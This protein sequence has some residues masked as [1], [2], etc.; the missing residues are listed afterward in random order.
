MQGLRKRVHAVLD[1]TSAHDRVGVLTHR[2]II[3]LILLNIAAVVLESVPALA[4]RWGVLFQ[5]VEIVTVAAF[6]VEYAARIWAA[7]EHPPLEDH[8]PWAARLR[9]ALYPS[10]IIDLVAILPLVLALF[11]DIDLRAAV[12]FRLLRYFKLARYSP[13][14][15]SLTEAVMAERRAL[16]ACLV[17]LFGAVLLCASAMHMVE[18][19][20]QPDKFGTIPDAMYWAVITLTTVGYGDVFPVTPAGKMITAFTA[21]AGLAMLALPVAIVSS[22][23]AREIHRR[24]FVVTWSMVAKVPLF[25]GLDAAAVAEIM[26][27]LQ[28]Q[29][30]DAGELIV[31]R[32][33]PAHSMYFIASGAVEIELPARRLVLQEGRFFG[34][35][36]LLRQSQRSGMVRA[37][38]RTRLLV[39]ESHDLHLVMAAYPEIAQRVEQVARERL[40]PEQVEPK[41]DIVAEEL[42]GKPAP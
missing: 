1:Q 27:Y 31:R 20:A 26:R 13:G 17:I 33:E 10:S 39:L 41:G 9:Y 22:A 7:P 35:I 6:A 36:S 24:D 12:V 8:G 15:T 18:A 16:G 4:E 28:S 38:E 21:I 5:T 3:A 19:Q 32:G 30:V 34:E 29:T 25:S 42:A 23:F 37:L 14:M 2:I 40:D 11:V